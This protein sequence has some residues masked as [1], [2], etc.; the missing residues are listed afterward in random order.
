VSPAKNANENQI[1]VEQ[2]ECR[3]SGELFSILQNHALPAR[4]KQKVSL[5]VMLLAFF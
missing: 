5:H 1:T 2:T 3:S 4:E